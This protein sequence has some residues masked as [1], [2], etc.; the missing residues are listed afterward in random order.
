MDPDQAFQLMKQQKQ[1]LQRANK[2]K[3]EIPGDR[4]PRQAL[5]SQFTMRLLA[6]S[7]KQMGDGHQI[8]TTF[9]PPAYLPCTVSL[10]NLRKIMIRELK[11]EI[12][13]RGRFL[14]LR[15]LTRPQRMTAVMAI[16]Q[17]EEDDAVLLQIYHQ[18]EENDK[19][20]VKV[21]NQGVVV[22]V[23]EPYFKQTGD[24]GYGLRIDHVSDIFWLCDDDARIPA[25]WQP[26]LKELKA[27]M[28]WKN[29]GNDAVVG[30]DFW[31]AI[32]CYTT[33][34][35]SH[36][37]TS[38]AKVI[39]RNRAHASLQVGQ[40]ES[41]LVDV[42][43]PFLETTAI[44]N[45]K[46]L[47]RAAKALY[48]LKRF[49]ECAETLKELS[50]DYPNN[51]LGKIEVQKVNIR[52]TEQDEGAYDFNTMEKEAE[53]T[54]PP[55]LD[56]ATFIG[57]VE[58]LESPG[59][60]RGLFLTKDIQVGDLILCE[61]AFAYSYAP[62]QDETF[63]AGCSSLSLFINTETDYMK[64]G[65]TADLITRIV[66]KISKNPSLASRFLVE[67]ITEL[68]SFGAGVTSLSTHI[69]STMMPSSGIASK[70]KPD[71][72]HSSGVWIQAS[73]INHSCM[74]NCRRSFIGDMQIVRA[75]QNMTPNTELVFPYKSIPTSHEDYK[76]K[77]DKF[78]QWG[79]ICDCLLCKEAKNLDKKTTRKMDGLRSDLAIAFGSGQK[80]AIN[81]GNLDT[82]KVQRILNSLEKC[83][84]KNTLGKLPRIEMWDPYLA[85]TRA[86][87][88]LNK[89]LEVIFSISKFLEV[90]AFKVTGMHDANS[91]IIVDKWGMVVDHLVEGWVLLW[92]TFA[93]LGYECKVA[94]V[95]TLARLSYKTVIGEDKTFEEV[96][97]SKARMHI[98]Q[99]RLWG[100]F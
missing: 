29:E 39:H 26:R 72:E 27:A 37:C 23:K 4:L 80:N 65:T 59:R 36:P 1:A 15:V 60:G 16:V 91:E 45:E 71:L 73:Y 30:K 19:P 56:H 32:L 14:L 12:H 28:A 81:I 9:V 85:L 57:P 63:A 78:K 43:Y 94:S 25:E 42:F 92:T 67:R 82:A 84:T 86:Y 6:Q 68:N 54:R 41:A 34:L 55:L 99:G 69:S 8:R 50:Q 44:Q 58:V 21:L 93:L 64:L 11:L 2:R 51:Q 40:F 90:L 17:D 48:A 97:G 33:A 3:G 47:F 75:T 5:L 83:Y 66:Q 20:A 89:P 62:P 13:H 76:T 22:I 35:E 52:L 49:R 53:R 95:V 38:E 70:E 98:G 46:A 79:F 18:D 7:M 74:A 96:Y 100:G 61:K 77:Q 87:A 88:M 24:G 31:K 10:K